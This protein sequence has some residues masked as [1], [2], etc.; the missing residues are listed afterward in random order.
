MGNESVNGSMYE[1]LQ[2]ISNQLG[3]DASI[4][5]IM[6]S[7]S[8]MVVI[9]IFVYT[10]TRNMILSAG[11]TITASIMMALMG[12]IPV[13][14]IAIAVGLTILA[15]YKHSYIDTNTIPESYSDRLIK[16]YEAKFGYV[17]PA[18][19]EEID[20]HI[21]AIENL[22][23]GYTRAVHRDKLKRLEKFVEMK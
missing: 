11:S 1:M 12:F 20:T 7:V 21:K 8:M 16:A 17:E 14:V 4:I 18:F 5:G 19:V 23:K 22:G 13:W 15:I 2:G 3:I 10:R 9:S 6:L